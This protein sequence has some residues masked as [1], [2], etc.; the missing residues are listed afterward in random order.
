M[1]TRLKRLV[2]AIINLLGYQSILVVPLIAEGEIIGTMEMGRREP[3]TEEDAKRLEA[4]AG[5]LTMAIRRKQAEEQIQK[6][7]E[8]LGT[9]YDL[10]RRL[11]E[12][13]DFNAILDVLTRRAVEATHVTFARVLLLEQDDLVVR[14]AFPVRLLNQDLQ[15]GQREPLAAHPFCQRVLEENTLQVL[16]LDSP[17]AGECAPF[18]IS[19]AKTLCFVPLRTRERLLGMLILGEERS[20]VREPFTAEKMDLVRN[21]GDQAG[22]TLHRALLHE[23][24]R[25]RMR[26]IQT[27]RDIDQA[28]TGSFD[29]R[30]T[31][32]ILLEHVTSQ[33]R[34]DAAAVLLLNPHTQTLEF[35]AGRGFRTDALQHTRLRVGEGYAGRAALE[36]QLIHIPDLRGRKTDFLRSP[37][38]S[39]E[40]F[41]AYYVVPL[42]A[43]G[44]VKGVLEIFHRAL[45]EADYEWRAFLE[46]LAGQAAIAVD[47]ANLFNNLQKANLEL[48]Q[49]Y[50]TTLEGWAHALELRDMETE[51]HSQRVT[52]MTS[53]L[54]RAL[55][56]SEE[57]LVQVRRGALLHD[58]GKMG[59]PDD[60]L[61]KPGPLTDEEW[62][63]M[64]QHPQFAFEMLSPIQYLNLA[65]DIPYCHHEKW[66][67]SGYPRGLKGEQ[68][69]LAARV[70]AV[71]D[72]WDALLSDRPYRKAWPMEKVVKYLKAESGKH[73]DPKVLEAFLKMQVADNGQQITE[74]NTPE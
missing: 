39:A 53:G 68:I 26:N 36:R 73:F 18:F 23:E 66:D 49:A 62:V 71:V 43:K 44:E 11:A 57:R 13:E 4:F 32:D 20:A 15:I 63:I 50:E 17:E 14:A 67:G 58:I 60:I 21:I 61:L 33:L 8:T 69:P 59:V 47:N 7:V 3:F 51:G 37:H 2:P 45:H 48:R 54:A 52:Q 29:L 22:S 34:V 16:Q 72:V 31:L 9:L 5:Q 12:M 70:F 10:S 24:T 1:R 6:Q 55:G 25:R 30:L 41:V 28:I 56:I 27:L 64:R 65:L 35:N 42:I 38:F 40:G 46:T 74:G 19:I